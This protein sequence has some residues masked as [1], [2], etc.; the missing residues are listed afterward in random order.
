MKKIMPLLLLLAVSLVLVSCPGP[1]SPSSIS[2]DGGG[3]GP[4]RH[5][6]FHN[7]DE[8]LSFAR[9]CWKKIDE[10]VY[11]WISPDCIRRSDQVTVMQI[12]AV[13]G[14]KPTVDEPFIINSSDSF[15][16]E[17][18]F[19][20]DLIS[21]GFH[22]TSGG[23]ETFKNAKPYGNGYCYEING[24]GW[25]CKVS[26]DWN[27]DPSSGSGSGSGGGSG[28]LDAYIGEYSYSGTYSGSIT[29]S[30]GSWSY[31]TS[32]AGAENAVVA[33][34][35]EMSGSNVK[36]YYTMPGV[37]GSLSEVFTVTINGSGATWRCIESN[38]YTAAT[39]IIFSGLFGVTDTQISFS[40]EE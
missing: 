22:K 29:V 17:D 35:A 26:S 36:L 9:G 13:G 2:D 12:D 27:Y 14:R 30:D 4:A 16:Y 18:V 6:P 20:N 11:W 38:G 32:K 25:F 24:E 21:I 3:N 34:S 15:P 28:S 1:E 7:Y 31:N 19:S 33:G 8:F 10:D 37:Q 23:F 39:S 40:Y 5:T